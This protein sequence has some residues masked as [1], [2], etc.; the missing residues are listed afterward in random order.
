MKTLLARNDKV[1]IMVHFTQYAEILYLISINFLTRINNKTLLQIHILMN[2]KNLYGCFQE[3]QGDQ[4]E[5]IREVREVN[6]QHLDY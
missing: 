3:G 1:S 5:T 2:L 6:A 4:Q